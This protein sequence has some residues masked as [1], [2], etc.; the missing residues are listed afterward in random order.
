ME[1]RK[2]KAT[3]AKGVEKWLSHPAIQ[4][5]TY[6]EVGREAKAQAEFWVSSAPHVI[7]FVAEEKKKAVGLAVCTSTPYHKA[8]HW[9]HFILIVDPA[10][11]GKGIGTALLNAA[12]EWC[13]REGV[14]RLVLELYES[15]YQPWFEKRGFVPFATAEGILKIQGELC[16][17][18]SLKKEIVC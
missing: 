6:V 11:W 5:Y 14:E 1:I 13:T 16:R 10:S 15:P 18:T 9:A 3:D 2:P 17:R 4:P 12:S 7:G 8:R